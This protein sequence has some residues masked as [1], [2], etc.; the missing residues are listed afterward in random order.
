MSVTTSFRVL[1]LFSLAGV[2]VQVPVPGAFAAWPGDPTVNVAITRLSDEEQHPVAVSDGADGAIVIWEITTGGL[3]GLDLVAQRVDA[4]GTV[5]WPSP[6][7]IVFTYHS[8]RDPQAIPDGAG[9]AIIVWDDQRTDIYGGDIYAQR[10]DAAGN[11]LWGTDGRLICS[12]YD[13]QAYPRLTSDGAGGAIITW[14]D[15]R[16][17]MITGV[18]IYAQRVTGLG[19]AVWADG[20][21]PICTA[22]ANQMDPIIVSDGAGGAIIAW[23]DD[24]DAESGTNVYMQ[25]VNGAGVPQWTAD[26]VGY[27]AYGNQ[28][29]NGTAIASDG[30]GGAMVAWQDDYFGA[31]DLDIRALRVDANGNFPWSPANVWICGANGC[32]YLRGCHGDGLGNM[33]ITWRDERYGAADPDVFAQYIDWT[34]VG[35]WGGWGAGVCTTHDPQEGSVAV[36]DDLGGAVIAWTDQRSG[37]DIYAQ[38]MGAGG[39]RLWTWN[40]QAVCTESHIQHTPVVVMSGSCG[41]VFAWTDLRWVGHPYNDTSWDI[42]G[43]RLYCDGSLS[44]FI[45]LDVPN[46]GEVWPAGTVHDITWH[47][48][49]INNRDV[50]IEYS[51]D[52]GANYGFVGYATQIGP[53]GSFPWTVPN[54]PSTQCRVRVWVWNPPQVMVRDESDANFTIS[55]G[56]GIADRP[57]PDLLTIEPA[58]P[59]PARGPV[60]LTLG[61]PHAAPVSARVYD[62]S[63]RLVRVVLDQS[64]AAGWWNLA[65][66]RTTQAGRRASP[67][68]YYW[69]IRTSGADRV[70]KVVLLD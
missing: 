66:D 18:N 53:V 50:T 23:M 25:R 65:W 10:I 15:S 59:N 30:M 1:L 48:A 69:A 57:A 39:E 12:A 22:I 36:L 6:A 13:V 31:D 43:Q 33:V 5:V 54:T 16:S 7:H 28:R 11:I 27:L 19:G 34:G 52:G 55:G 44:Q 37:S 62:V 56:N 2:T 32:Q 14:R 38:R 61:L 8:Q 35:H 70:E 68:V 51:T 21:V 42:Y 20:G 4:N 41:G 63:G 64:L 45:A 3:Y 67:G 58:R 40:G 49:G 29:F 26:G 46:G 60:A 9:G 24:R 47:C 17:F